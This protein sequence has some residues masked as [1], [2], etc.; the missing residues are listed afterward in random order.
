[1]LTSVI[2]ARIARMG[3]V[4]NTHILSCPLFGKSEQH[5]V[6]NVTLAYL[7]SNFQYVTN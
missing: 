4:I 3:T 1:M 2:S 6:Q 7:T 5:Y